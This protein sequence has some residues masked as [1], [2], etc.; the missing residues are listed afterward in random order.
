[1]KISQAAGA[2]PPTAPV[3]GI[4]TS[5][6]T[7]TAGPAKARELFVSGVE[8]FAQR[9]FHATT[10]RD[11]AS[12]VGLSPAGLYVHFSS[13]EE[14]LFEI[15]RFGHGRLLALMTTAAEAKDPTERLAE[16]ARVAAVFHAEH[17]TLARVNQNEFRALGSEHFTTVVELRREIIALTTSAVRAGKRS[18]AFDVGDVVG[19]STALLSL[20]LDVARW[21]PSRDIKHVERVG[22][23][24]AMLSLRMVGAKG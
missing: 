22:A 10:T 2:D 1:M 17:H 19:T 11:I 23:L 6:D 4:L 13:K 5:A 14:L 7:W 12:G 21:F 9:G 18:G 24:Y 16:L 8:A 15:C 3:P 20:W